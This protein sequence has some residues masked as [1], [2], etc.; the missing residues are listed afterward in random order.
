MPIP[1]AL[2]FPEQDPAVLW[3]TQA[4]GQVAALVQEVDV[5]DLKVY[6]V[7]VMALFHM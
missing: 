7:V 6:E 3:Q 1:D 4:E 2:G 5:L